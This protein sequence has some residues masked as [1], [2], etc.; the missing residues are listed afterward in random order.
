MSELHIRLYSGVAFVF[1]QP[2]TRPRWPRCCS[3]HVPAP[4]GQIL[5][6]L[7][8]R[9]C[10]GVR[11]SR[12][13]AIRFAVREKVLREEPLFTKFAFTRLLEWLDDGVES[14]GEKYLEMRRR[15]VSYFDQRLR[16]AADELAD[17]TFSR[18]AR[19]LGE[20]GVIAV[21]PPARYCFV[22]AKF[23]LLEDFRRH[24]RHV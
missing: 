11:R 22:V 17:E 2:R 18:I 14:H 24:R 4:C 1:F 19:T 16:P 5:P 8:Q 3:T 10:L 15:L 23:V 12:Q 7:N 20:T 6:G 21:T 13:K 9:I